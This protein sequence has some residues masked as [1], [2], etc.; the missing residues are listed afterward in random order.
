MASAWGILIGSGLIAGAWL[1]PIALP[2]VLAAALLAQI[3]RGERRIPALVLVLV[4]A[5]AG[6]V[7]GLD[8]SSAALPNDLSSSTGG[9]G[10]V[11]SLPSPSRSG[12]RVLVSV[13]SVRS[14]GSRSASSDFIAM[15]WLPEN[16][17][18]A[19]GDRISVAWSIE[20]AS[21]I[22]P[23]F[24]SYVRSQS[25]EAVGYVSTVENIEPGTSWTR[26]LVDLRRT[27]TL[28]FESALPGDVGALASGIVTGDDSALS[29]FSRDAFLRTGTSH[30]TAVSGSNVSM[31]LALWSFIVR[32]GRFRRTALVQFAIIL[33]IWLYAILV[34][35]E[36]PAVRAALVASLGLLAVRSGRHP[37]PMTL[38]F[39]ASAVLVMWNPEVTAMIA[40]WLSFVASA[41][42]IGRLPTEPGMG[43]VGGT[44]A[45]GSGVF[46][47]YLGTLPIVLAVFG[48]WSISAVLANAVL[49]PLMTLAFPLSFL[50]GAVLVVA[51]QLGEVV[52]WIPGIVLTVALVTVDKVSGM[53]SPLEFRTTGWIG[54]VPVAMLCAVATLAF[55]Q[56][57]RRWAV[58]AAERW[59]QS[60][61]LV[62]VLSMAAFA[63]VA[64]GAAAA[65]IH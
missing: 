44:K 56:D 7:R 42:L 48:T 15:L 37:D 63:G 6:A 10:S 39:V 26:Q 21:V 1:G 53:A 18:V 50:L 47:A 35:L 41:A 45:V 12:D 59:R 23:G 61:S 54:V 19:P 11:I 46:F 34:G 4:A 20:D 14:I 16:T 2:I 3:V 33:T 29:D 58:L 38:L 27:L 30:I 36:P 31:L 8:D 40:F 28:R 64:C 43:W 32:P 24:G 51:P 57:G 60:P 5:A 22:G 13:A 52:A 55:S 65:L 62:V 9:T 17:R 25:A 49:A